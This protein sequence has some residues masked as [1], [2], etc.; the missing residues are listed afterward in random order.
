MYKTYFIIAKKLSQTL[1][2]QFFYNGKLKIRRIEINIK[3]NPTYFQETTKFAKKKKNST[4]LS[5]M[6]FKEWSFF[7]TKLTN[8]ASST[9]TAFF[10][11]LQKSLDTLPIE[12]CTFGLLKRALSE[13]KFTMTDILWNVDQEELE[14]ITLEILMKFI[15]S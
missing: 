10:E 14:S 2:L 15:L 9:T 5:P 4:S 7:K 1:L 11:I 12:Y 6:T 13:H 8:L 3:I